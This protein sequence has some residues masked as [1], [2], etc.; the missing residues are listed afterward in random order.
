MFWNTVLSKSAY[1]LKRQIRLSSFLRVLSLNMAMVPGKPPNILVQTVEEDIV[2]SKNLIKVLTSIVR[3]DKYVLYSAS[4]EVLR[5]SAWKKNTLLLVMIKSEAFLSKNI[6]D[7]FQKGGKLLD[8]SAEN[9]QG[10]YKRLQDKCFQGLDSEETENF[11]TIFAQLGID[12]NQDCETTVNDNIG[13]II[14]ELRSLEAFL[15][16]RSENE[17]EKIVKQSRMS[18]DFGCIQTYEAENY[19]PIYPGDQCQLYDHQLFTSHLQTKHLGR[20]LLYVPVISSSMAPFEGKPLGHGFTV[21]PG[22][23]SS[24]V[25]RGG[26][27]WLSPPGCSMFSMQICFKLDT[28]LGRRPS[29]IQ[30]LVALAQVA[31]LRDDDSSSHL[32]FR[33]KW[34][35]DIYFGQTKIGGV[36]VKSSICRDELAITVGAGINLNN[37]N[38]TLCINQIL[39]NGGCQVLQQ[40]VFQAR[41][42]NKLEEI[43]EKCS[44]NDYSTVEK[45]YYKYWLHSGQQI[46][47]RSSASDTEVT[48]IG[49][50]EFGF[51]RVKDTN[52]VE[53]SVMDDGNSFD[54]MEGLVRPRDQ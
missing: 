6:E 18:L 14:S 53:F 5:Q 24:G 45:L 30:H 52:D 48:V 7:Y 4:N 33:I 32:D 20:I 39:Q 9:I 46:V 15:K 28:F 19:L 44:S 23:Q 41:V 17:H 49:I 47:V 1:L 51:L 37:S 27:K 43:I 42:F 31:V 3:K 12:I 16:Q 11:K 22:R 25:G 36:V 10:F 26:N 50:D 29:L 2:L 21:V 40:E 13:Y 38:P 8:L 54:M 34:P 35:N